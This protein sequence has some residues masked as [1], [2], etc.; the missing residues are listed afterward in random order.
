[1]SESSIYTQFFSKVAASDA[2]KLLRTLRDCWGRSQEHDL[3]DDI[4]T[5][6]AGGEPVWIKSL[7]DTAS[8]IDSQM[9]LYKL[10]R[11]NL[12]PAFRRTCDE[13]LR[14]LKHDVGSNKLAV[15][16]LNTAIAEYVTNPCPATLQDVSQAKEAP[17][18]RFEQNSETLDVLLKLA[19][20]SY[21]THAVSLLLENP[22]GDI[23]T[24]QTSDGSGG[25]PR[26]RRGKTEDQA[27]A[28]SAPSQTSVPPHPLACRLKQRITDIARNLKSSKDPDSALEECEAASTLVISWI[29]AQCS[30]NEQGGGTMVQ[31]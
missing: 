23:D 26:K 1:M 7:R 14:K 24:L 3:T 29:D 31:T 4:K 16:T 15:Q 20:T 11:S 27:G 2:Y 21:V 17:M 8:A 19:A 22:H 28:P 6:N 30:N 10:G 25:P 13:I 12:P 18:K 9:S 5:I